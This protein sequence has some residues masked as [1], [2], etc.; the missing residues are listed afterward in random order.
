MAL[1]VPVRRFT[2]FVV[3]YL[4]HSSQAFL[5]NKTDIRLGTVTVSKDMAD[6]YFASFQLGSDTP[7]IEKF[8]KIASLKPRL[9]A[10]PNGA[11]SV[12][13]AG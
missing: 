8:A 10:R 9:K 4:G 3:D 12:S 6:H 5:A 11:R 1:K 13:M 2:R 7:F